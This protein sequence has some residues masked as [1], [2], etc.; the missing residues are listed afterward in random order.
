MRSPLPF[1][2]LAA[3]AWSGGA[4]ARGPVTAPSRL[5]SAP[6]LYALTRDKPAPWQPALELYRRP[7][8]PSSQLVCRTS[9]F[10]GGA[11]D[12]FTPYQDCTLNLQVSRAGGGLTLHVRKVEG[13]DC[14]SDLPAAR[15]LTEALTR[16]QLVRADFVARVR[17]LDSR[18][19]VGESGSWRPASELLQPLP[20]AELLRLFDTVTPFVPERM[21]PHSLMEELTSVT[22]TALHL[23][24]TVDNMECV[25]GF[26]QRQYPKPQDVERRAD[27]TPEELGDPTPSPA[28]KLAVP[29]ALASQL[30]GVWTRPE[31]DLDSVQTVS[32]RVE[33]GQLHMTFQHQELS[34][35]GQLLE[36]ASFPSVDCAGAY[37]RQSWSRL[38]CADERAVK[39]K[40]QG[41]RLVVRVLSPGWNTLVEPRLNP[42]EE[43]RRVDP[44]AL[45]AAFLR[46]P[47]QGHGANRYGPEL[48]QD[49]STVLS[50]WLEKA[51]PQKVGAFLR[52]RKEAPERLSA[53]RACNLLSFTLASLMKRCPAKD[54]D[55]NACIERELPEAIREA[56][57]TVGSAG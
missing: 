7:M 32:A 16:V 30:A 13:A 2:M 19:K 52:A 55:R 53:A 15:Q 11:H 48:E 8:V 31:L 22:A 14:P 40:L 5:W 45:E 34:S 23:C 18:M 24:K 51:L 54:A 38:A 3:L 12:C 57:G 42:E 35:S 29:K 21:D 37:V 26:L 9:V 25:Q 50:D 17:S 20:D 49:L 39:V 44:L 41:A 1:L 6:D 28:S 47:L 56:Y 33:S 36:P 43:Y 27:L 4:L 10:Q 46:Y